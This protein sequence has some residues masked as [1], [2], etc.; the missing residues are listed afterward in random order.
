VVEW[1]EFN[2]ELICSYVH[3]QADALRQY[4]KAPIGTDLMVDN[5]LSYN[6]MNKKLDVVQHNHYHTTDNLYRSLFNYDFY[7]PLKDRPFWV[8]ETLLG[9]NGST[10]AA[11]GY[12][13]KEYSYINSL[14]SV[15]HGSEM[16]LYWL[17]RA[18]PNGHEL[19]HGAFLNSSG[20]P[21]PASRGV[22]MLADTLTKAEDF[23][24]NSKPKSKIAMTYSSNSV[25]I[26]FWAQL[27]EEMVTDVRA[28]YIDLCHN[29][30]RHYNIDVIET[31]KDLSEYEVI[32]SPFLPNAARDGF[33]KRIVEWIENGGT[34]IVGPYTDIMT[35]CASKY[36]DKPYSFL[37]DLCG[38]YTKYQL[39]IQDK[40]IT[41]KWNDG[42]ELQLFLGTDAYEMVDAESLA[43]Y[44]SDELENLTAIARRKVG[45]GQVIIL[46]SAIDKKSMLKLVNKAPT[47]EA[48]E[49]ID[50]TERSGEENGI[51]AI[52][53][54]G[55]D[56]YIV[57][58]REYYDVLNEKTVSGRI[59]L[60]PYDACILK[61]I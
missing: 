47:L 11:N 5:Y 61:E 22:K 24:V 50:L 14:L 18:H 20:R 9:W 12:R 40:N 34:W 26:F 7:R 49:N 10:Y 8:T 53:I 31:D 58:E 60:K 57:L 4:T 45:K 43:T 35:E 27:V 13:P 52:E 48:S 39:P 37:E 42:E 38:V 51:I 30:F 2:E 21:N 19:G 54:E 29:Y 17:F 3:E 15:A 32:V 46:G 23:L 25:K 55:K 59:D 28:K 16:N 1:V 6:K 56:G 44:E 33:E 41:A 36:T